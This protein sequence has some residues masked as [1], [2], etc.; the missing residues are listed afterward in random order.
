M[1]VSKINVFF[2][3]SRDENYYS[4]MRTRTV[5]IEGF[6]L[7]PGGSPGNSKIQVKAT[8]AS[9]KKSEA[10][11]SALYEWRQLRKIRLG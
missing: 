10:L 1:K 3:T 11:R 6:F 5:T 7:V 8:S 9:T 4:R 2:E